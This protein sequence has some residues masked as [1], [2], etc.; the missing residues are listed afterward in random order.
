[1]AN[2][3]PWPP[4]DGAPLRFRKLCKAHLGA[5]GITDPGPIVTVAPRG[6]SCR[7]IEPLVGF[8]PVLTNAM[9]FVVHQAEHV[10]RGGVVLYGSSAIPSCGLDVALWDAATV[11]LH[12]AEMGL[13]RGN[14]TLGQG[15]QYRSC[16]DIVF[17]TE[18]GRARPQ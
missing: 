6:M 18:G 8:D 2:V 1:M 4:V 10:L 15:S 7:Q 5:D 9:A 14:A 16:G 3:P 13:R 17:T 11:G 12:E